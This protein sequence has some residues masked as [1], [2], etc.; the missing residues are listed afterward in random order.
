MP[1]KGVAKSGI[2][3]AVVRSVK[4]TV[5]QE[6]HNRLR[7]KHDPPPSATRLL[8]KLHVPLAGRQLDGRYDP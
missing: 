5:L 1:R 7:V 8:E 4:D 3:K 6:V 2:A